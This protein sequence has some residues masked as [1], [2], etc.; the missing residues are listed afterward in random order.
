M[1]MMETICGFIEDSK[2]NYENDEGVHASPIV[3]IKSSPG[4]PRNSFENDRSSKP[5]VDIKPADAI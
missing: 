3:T 1:D 2:A 5:T 4:S